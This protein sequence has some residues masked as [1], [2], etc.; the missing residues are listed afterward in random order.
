MA[1]YLTCLRCKSAAVLDPAEANCPRC[2]QE[3]ADELAKRK[4]WWRW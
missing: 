3:L 2:K 4:V 1:K